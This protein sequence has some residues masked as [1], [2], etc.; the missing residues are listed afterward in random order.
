ETDA[1]GLHDQVLECLEGTRCAGTDM[2][3]DRTWVPAKLAPIA[4]FPGK[5]L[6][7]L[8]QADGVDRV[9]SV[10]HD[11]DRVERD[12]VLDLAA[13]ERLQSGR[14]GKH[15]NFT[16]RIVARGHADLRDPVGDAVLGGFRSG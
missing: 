14:I 5:D 8:A 3:I 6:C 15:S 10:H 16:V 7:D 2:N 11:A 4:N 1:A 13:L 9:A 12:D